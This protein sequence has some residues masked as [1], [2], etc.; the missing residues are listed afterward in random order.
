MERL[1]QFIKRQ[2]KG[3]SS[4]HLD[5]LRQRVQHELAQLSS[6]VISSLTSYDFILY[7]FILEDLFH[8][9]LFCAAS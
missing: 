9:A 2:F 5:Q 4:S 7:D 8:Q 3:E 1:W 6:A